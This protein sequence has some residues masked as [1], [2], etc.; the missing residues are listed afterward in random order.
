MSDHNQ[1]HLSHLD[2]RALLRAGLG[3][4]GALSL[5]GPASAN[6]RSFGTGRDEDDHTL[7]LLQL[8]GGNDCLSTLVPFGD[9]AYFRARKQTRIEAQKL[10]KLNDYCGLHPNLKRLAKRYDRGGLA[11][12]QGVGYPGPTRS[13]F[14]ALEVWHTADLAGKASGDGWIGKLCNSRWAASELPELTVHLGKRVPY[15]LHSSAHPP[16]AFE[17][18]ESYRWMGDERDREELEAPGER[19]TGSVLDRLRGVMR[20]AQASSAR[21]RSAAARY[22]PQVEY[23]NTPEASA[24]A[25]AAAL[26]DAR[27]G[28]RVIS[29]EFSG[30]DTHT[31]Q[32]NAHDKLMGV[33]DGALSAFLDDLAGREAGDKTTVLV[34]SE[35]GRRV[36]ENGSG[37]TDHGKGGLL[38][39]AGAPVRG[40]LYGKHPSLTKLDA[41]DLAHNVDFRRA[42]ASVVEWL[43]GDVETVLGAGYEP[44]PFMS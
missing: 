39:A 9:D 23:P 3:L 12:V 7:V 30:F 15:S 31:T 2:R 44:L 38:F 29:V 10:H 17:V 8:S 43:G 42:Y 6:L 11:I 32:R 27:L 14:K 40:G 19:K 18:P 20:D 13:H 22:R 25:H 37:G 16:V 36:Q 35:F 5:A 21:I 28:S 1:Q 34:F 24:L 33:L 4:F 26:I 41:E